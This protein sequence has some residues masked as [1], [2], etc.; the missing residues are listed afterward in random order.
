MDSK[1]APKVP[2]WV[3]FLYPHDVWL[4]AKELIKAIPLMKAG[5]SDESVNRLLKKEGL[6]KKD[7]G[8]VR[9]ADILYGILAYKR[10]LMTGIQDQTYNMDQ[11][12]LPGRKEAKLADRKSLLDT[13]GDA[14]VAD[15]K[16]IMKLPEAPP[17]NYGLNA[18]KDDP[19]PAPAPAPAPV[20][21][22]MKGKSAPQK[23][24]I[25]ER[26][27]PM[28]A[29]EINA[30]KKFIIKRKLEPV[31]PLSD[32]EKTKKKAWDIIHQVYA[33]HNYTA[34]YGR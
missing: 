24:E 8:T 4:R 19:E 1:V 20:L 2:T 9:G 18:Y 23:E 11:T 33:L 3:K 22:P 6:R 17:Y 26:G 34:N 5:K 29:S 14:V 25:P 21:A 10:L 28:T 16:E 32:F 30:R 27:E 12:Y 31:K 7:A 15:A 13:Y